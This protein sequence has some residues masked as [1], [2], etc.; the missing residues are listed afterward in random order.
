MWRVFAVLSLFLI[1][2]CSTEE[3]PVILVRVQ[4]DN[5]EYVY[6]YTEPITVGDFLD[7]AE[8]EMDPL[9]RVYPE[10]WT[11]I[12]DEMRITVVRVEEDEYCEE[13]TISFDQQTQLVEGLEGEQRIG[14]RGENGIE[15]VCYRVRVENGVQQEPVETRRVTIK[16]PV[17]EIVFVRPEDDLEPVPID[18]T[19]A[20]ISNSNAWIIR[21]NTSFKRPLTT[22]GDLDNRVFTLSTDGRQLLFSR[23]TSDDA[24]FNQL[25]YAPDTVSPEPEFIQLVPQDVLHADWVPNQPNTFSYSTAERRDAAPGWRAFNDLWL[26]S[27]N[28]ETG[29]QINIDPVLEESSGGIAGWWGTEFIWSPDGT[30]LAWVQADRIGLVDLDN[31]ALDDAL[32]EYVFY[33]TLQDWSWRTSVSWSPDSQL[34]LATTHGDPIGDERPEASPVFDVDVVAADGSYGATVIERAGI[35]ATPQFSPP[36][37][38]TDTEGFIAYLQAREWASSINGAYDLIVAD[39]DGSNARIIFP[40][41]DDQPGLTEASFAQHFTWSPDGRQIALIYLGNLWV[42]DVDTGNAYQITQ[43]GNASKPVWAR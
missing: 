39:R 18:G 24:T 17:D 38:G 22:S 4:V 34:L 3:V 7:E 1:T 29:Q 23:S 31:G 10:E 8:I 13:E 12:Y 15:Q 26:M 11:Q 9:D 20:Y 14:Q 36:V 19:L 43:D 2:S 27:I 16:E 35:W 5:S 25:W 28:P 33:N 41:D 30:R 6:Q 40:P 37:D 42:V 21:G 32:L